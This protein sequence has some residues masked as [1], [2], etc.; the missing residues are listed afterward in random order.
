MYECDSGVGYKERKKKERYTSAR[1]RLT[2]EAREERLVVDLAA[3]AREVA[4]LVLQRC[5]LALQ[6]RL[7]VKVREGVHDAA[8]GRGGR[9]RG[10]TGVNAVVSGRYRKGESRTRS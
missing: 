6:L 2:L 4:R 7:G 5:E 3:L 10:S 1:R 9:G 8:P